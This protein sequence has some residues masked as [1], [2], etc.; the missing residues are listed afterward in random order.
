MATA[1]AIVGLA[2]P[3]VE[4]DDIATTAK[5]LPDFPAMWAGML[6]DER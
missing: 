3:G 4:V 5:T 1:G 2:V 6:G